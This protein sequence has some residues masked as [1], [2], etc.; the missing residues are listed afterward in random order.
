MEN[1]ARRF[2]F[3]GFASDDELAEAA[4]QRLADRLAGARER[5]SF[6]SLALSGGRIAGKLFVVAAKNLARLGGVGEQS[7]FFWADERCVPPDHPDSNYR[8]ALELLLH[9]LGVAPA[10]IHRIPGELDPAEAALRASAALAGVLARCGV[11]P[12]RLDLALLGMGEDGHIAS[13]FP[14]EPVETTSDQALFRAVV[15]PKP[16]PNRVTMGYS[17]L[18]AA[19]ETWVIVSGSGKEEALRQSLSPEGNTPLA[20]LLRMQPDACVFSS[21]TPAT[22]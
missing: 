21:V 20:R 16:P 14:A 6:F 17:T 7:H 13:L 8:T 9:P 12:A 3:Q 5:S 22:P 18:A 4:G 15:G 10:Q 2:E 19:R 1:K 11:L